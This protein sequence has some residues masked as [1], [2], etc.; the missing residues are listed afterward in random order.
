MPDIARN[1]Q[2]LVKEEEAQSLT[3]KLQMCRRPNNYRSDLLYEVANA[4]GIS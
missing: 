3:D 1:G 2:F 4:H